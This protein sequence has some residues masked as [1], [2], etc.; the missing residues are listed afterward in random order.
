[1]STL[2]RMNTK[3]PSLKVRI[4][5]PEGATGEAWHYWIGESTREIHIE[6]TLPDG[7]KAQAIVYV[8]CKRRP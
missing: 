8:K 5:Y 7:Q 3:A 4:A 2:Q 6:I 1:M